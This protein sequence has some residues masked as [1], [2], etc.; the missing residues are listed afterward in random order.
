MYHQKASH[1]PRPIYIHTKALI[2]FPPINLV[3]IGMIRIGEIEY[4]S[5]MWL[6]PTAVGVWPCKIDISLEVKA[7]I[8]VDI[9]IERFEVCW[10]VDDPNVARLDEIVCDHDVFLVWG[11]FDVMGANGRLIFIGI[12]ET[13]GIIQVGYVEGGNVIGCC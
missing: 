8:R 4:D 3:I 1:P 11:D 2:P 9:Y 7:T 13:F 5:A 12:V 6:S 10:C